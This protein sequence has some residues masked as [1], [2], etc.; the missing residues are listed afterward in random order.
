M[1][2][3]V[4]PMTQ[5]ILTTTSETPTL[6]TLASPAPAQGSL[7][8]AT[9]SLWRREMVRF[10]RQRS[11]V[12]GAFA[13][14]V[15][16]WFVIGS[17][18]GDSMPI[19]A[20]NTTDAASAATSSSD[21]LSYLVFFYPGTIVM[22][23]LFTA[24]FSTISVIEDR[25]EGFLQGVLVAP[26]PRL[27][28]V[29]GKVFGGASVGMIQGLILL[30]AWPLIG[31]WPGWLAMVEGAAVMALLAVAL[32]SLGLCVAWPMRST[33]GFHGIMMLFLLPMWMLSGSLF[34]VTGA[35]G[36]IKSLMYCNPLMYGYAAFSAIITGSAQ[37]V[38][39]PVSVL[40]ALLVTV[41][42]TVVMLL[43]AVAIVRRPSEGGV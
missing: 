31:G 32:T 22:M 28:I 9:T 5:S 16:F 11:R 41:A 17:G 36:W 23:L 7:V 24:I 38:G 19:S 27:A 20:G 1:Q 8:L 10:F 39:A 43:T 37:G 6:S 40:P 34:P 4:N 42:F 25:R 15:F 12:I 3:L 35:V 14:P 30:A 21:H 13:Q 2:R 26:I 29:L 33:A 18:V